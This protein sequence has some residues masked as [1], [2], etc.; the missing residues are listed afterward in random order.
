[1]AT[2]VLLTE[3]GIKDIKNAPKR[4]EEAAQ[5][6]HKTTGKLTSVFATFGKH[7][8]VAITEA[9]NDEVAMSYLLRLS[10]QGNVRITTTKLVM[11]ETATN[12]RG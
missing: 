12:T 11:N 1:M 7:A 10:S 2:Y 4:L 8:Y 5:S 6:I 9:P 3:Q